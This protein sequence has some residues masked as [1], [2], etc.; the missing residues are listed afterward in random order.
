MPMK[1]SMKFVAGLGVVLLFALA[2]VTGTQALL[3][4]QQTDDGGRADNATRVAV[5]SPEQRRMEESVTAT[6]AMRRSSAR[7]L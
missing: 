4:V 6:G 7:G 1:R 5:A 2:G 3:L